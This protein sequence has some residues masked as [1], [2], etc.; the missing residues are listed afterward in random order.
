MNYKN[1]MTLRRFSTAHLRVLKQKVANPNV[2]PHNPEHRE[3]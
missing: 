1:L 2:T 3:G